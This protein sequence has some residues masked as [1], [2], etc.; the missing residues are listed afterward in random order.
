MT[1]PWPQTTRKARVR[2]VMMCNDALIVVWCVSLVSDSVG[3]YVA[4]AAHVVFVCV[5]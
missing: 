1:I 5:T 4:R 3:M 2:Y